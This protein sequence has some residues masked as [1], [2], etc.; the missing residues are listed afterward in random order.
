M[1]A[2]VL[3]EFQILQSKPEIQRINILVMLNKM[4]RLIGWDTTLILE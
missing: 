1:G 2:L 4:Y 3:V